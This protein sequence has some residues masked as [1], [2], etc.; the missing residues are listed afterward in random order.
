MS[1]VSV[2]DKGVCS[3]VGG[4]DVD[5]SHFCCCCM[6]PFSVAGAVSGKYRL[7]AAAV[8][9]GHVGKKFCSSAWISVD[10]SGL[11]RHWCKYFMSACLDVI[12]YAL[13]DVSTLL[14]VLMSIMLL[15]VLLLSNIF[16]CG[17]LNGSN[18]SPVHGSRFPLH[19][20][21]LLK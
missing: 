3:F 6:C 17:V 5:C 13:N 4:V 1:N 12:L 20:S 19:I 15:F 18:H 8:K 7:T 21:L 11:K 2:V 14:V 9:P 10:F 16:V